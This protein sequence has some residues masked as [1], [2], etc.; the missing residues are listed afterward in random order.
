MSREDAHST[1]PGVTRLHMGTRWT[2]SPPPVSEGGD[3][4]RK[5]RLLRP[6]TELQHTL[7]SVNDL[8]PVLI[9]PEG[10]QE[11]EVCPVTRRHQGESGPWGGGGGCKLQ[12]WG[13]WPSVPS[14]CL[15]G[16]TSGK[17]PAC[18]CRRHKR[19]G[20]DPWVGKSPWK[21]AWQPTLV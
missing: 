15:P 2:Q 12:G 3:H 17:E 8:C 5:P 7:P 21:R 19:H 14:L 18:R 4:I 10:V 9:L 16:G 13:Q 20:F 11:A 6:R 1:G